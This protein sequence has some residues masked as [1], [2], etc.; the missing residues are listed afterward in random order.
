M[1]NLLDQSLL[2]PKT[3]YQLLASTIDT[4]SRHIHLSCVSECFNFLHIKIISTFVAL[5][6]HTGVSA[7]S[8]LLTFV[9]FLF[10]LQETKGKS[11]VE[12]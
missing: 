2:N 3:R 5:L 1:I 12:D 9:Y 7:A 10:F 6:W 8:S 11:M 4:F